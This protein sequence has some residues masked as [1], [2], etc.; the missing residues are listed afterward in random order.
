M[1]FMWG[2]IGSFPLSGTEAERIPMASQDKASASNIF[3]G[4]FDKVMNTLEDLIVQR[5]V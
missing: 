3:T 2:K 1:L 4:E 5:D